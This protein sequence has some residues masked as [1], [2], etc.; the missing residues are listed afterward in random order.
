M[1]K[2]NESGI[3]FASGSGAKSKMYTKS[4]ANSNS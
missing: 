2:K 3:N 1:F 4:D